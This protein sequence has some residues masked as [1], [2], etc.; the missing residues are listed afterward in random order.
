MNKTLR[1]LWNFPFNFILIKTNSLKRGVFGIGI[2]KIVQMFVR[3]WK[4]RENKIS[5][6][7]FRVQFSMEIAQ[8]TRITLQ[9]IPRA[10][11]SNVIWIGN[12]KSNFY[13]TY[14]RNIRQ[15][16]CWLSATLIGSSSGSSRNQLGFVFWALLFA[17]SSALKIC[18]FGLLI[19]AHLA[20]Q[21]SHD[22]SVIR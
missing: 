21:A 9:S 5:K 11:L 3:E 7:N 16:N 2:R 17:R 18:R 8:R 20:R 15:R 4:L 10:V 14:N 22:V 1:F 19:W 6:I 12:K 13:S